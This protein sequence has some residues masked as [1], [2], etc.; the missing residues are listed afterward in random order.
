MKIL[1]LSPNQQRFVHPV[2]PIGALYL[3]A[4]LREM[5][6][7]VDLLD[8]M[9]IKDKNIELELKNKL[10][11][12]QPDLFCISIRNIDALIG[13]TEYAMP[14]LN[15]CVKLARKYSSA[16]I[17][18]GGP[19]YSLFPDKILDMLNAD[20]GISG[21]A[22]ES[23]PLL[24]DRLEKEEKTS[25]IA[26]LCFKENEVIKQNKPEI[27]CNL[28]KVPFQA[29]DLINAKQ[30]D[31][32]RGAMGIFTRKACPLDCIYCPEAY[33]HGNKVRF[34]S[35]KKVAD[36]IEYI[37]K[38]A[39]VHYFDFADTTFNVPKSHSIDVCN[40][41]INRKLDFR[42]EVELSPIQQDIE[43]AK[44]LKAAGC[45]GIDLTADSGSNKM[46]KYLNKGFSAQDILKTAHIYKKL[47]IPY[48]V[49]FLLGGP[50][51][52]EETIKE[53][54]NIACQL[55][56]PNAVYFT[57]GIRI[58]EQTELY[59]S[60]NKTDPNYSNKNLLDPVFYVSES[61]TQN[62]ADLL[63]DVCSKRL[64]FYISDIFYKPLMRK[65]MGFASL[66]NIRPA[67]KHSNAPKLLL[68]ILEGG[69]NSLFWDNNKRS[70]TW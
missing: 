5:G 58:F 36:E 63:L 44:I 33:F 9:F 57:V 66:L 52:D 40:E 62:C 53:S 25:D 18:L 32:N 45:E 49:G 20:Y 42:F 61:F 3:A 8:L 60:L 34:R 38:E 41:I 68:K 30:Y 65:I 16:K 67:W 51:E 13:K 55:P 2:P 64:N 12:Y 6:H 29:I 22:D 26:G 47:K 28:N 69:G 1:F 50:G 17:I 54:I 21:E 37:I 46:L 4:S 10:I 35:P 14:L 56:D 24:V 39:G 27:V 48:T 59:Q 31:R 7:D 11:N 23:L 70:F 19:G 15:Q 43:S